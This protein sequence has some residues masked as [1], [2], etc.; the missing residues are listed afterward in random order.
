M[1]EGNED[2]RAEEMDVVAAANSAEER[3][4]R[5]EVMSEAPSPLAWRDQGASTWDA[6]SMLSSPSM[7]EAFYKVNVPTGC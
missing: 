7:H 5:A 6:L 2:R 4:P 3:S 1:N